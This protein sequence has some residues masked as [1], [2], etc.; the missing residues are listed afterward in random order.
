MTQGVVSHSS[1]PEAHDKISLNEKKKPFLA[2]VPE[3]SVPRTYFFVAWL[4]S[5][6]FFIQLILPAQRMTHLKIGERFMRDS[7]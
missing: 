2:D 7:F 1:K 5:L 3:G 4:C 6:G